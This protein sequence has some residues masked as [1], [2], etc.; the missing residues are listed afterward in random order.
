MKTAIFWV[1]FLGLHGCAV[2]SDLELA[3][4]EAAYWAAQGVDIR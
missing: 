1:L 4:R 2:S 3:E